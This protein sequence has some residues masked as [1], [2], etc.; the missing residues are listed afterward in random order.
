MSASRTTPG[1]NRD[2]QNLPVPLGGMWPVRVVAMRRRHGLHVDRRRIGFGLGAAS[3]AAGLALLLT[4]APVAVSLIG[5]RLEVGGMVLTAAAQPAPRQ[6][7]RFGGDASYVL[8]ER[9]DGSASAA[10]SWVSGGTTSTGVCTLRPEGVRL[11]ETCS[12]V[13]GATRSTAVD[14][15]DPAVG[16]LWQRTFGDGVRATIAVSPDGSA[17]PVPFPIGR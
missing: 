5:D 3:G 11:V 13:S 8:L 2:R 1:V 17:V 16:P 15:L 12:F 14:V 7:V 6:A 9:S 4:P 10:A